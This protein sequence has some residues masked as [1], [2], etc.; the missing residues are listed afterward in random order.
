MPQEHIVAARELIR[1]IALWVGARSAVIMSYRLSRI[2]RCMITDIGV[3]GRG[4]CQRQKGRQYC[5][6]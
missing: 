1:L 4:D 3:T 2:G 6:M 5:C